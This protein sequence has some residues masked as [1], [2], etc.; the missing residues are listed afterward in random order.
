MPYRSMIPCPSCGKKAAPQPTCPFCH[1]PLD[2]STRK[3]TATPSCTHPYLSSDT[4]ATGS[5]L[6]PRTSCVDKPDADVTKRMLAFLG[7]EIGSAHYHVGEGIPEQKYQNAQKRMKVPEDDRILAILDTT[8]FESGK[9]GVAFGEKHVYTRRFRMSYEELQKSEVLPLRKN[10]IQI[11]SGS[12]KFTIFCPSF[13][14]QAVRFVRILCG[15]SAVY[16]NA[17]TSLFRKP[18]DLRDELVWIARAHTLK[19]DF[20]FVGAAIWKSVAA[21][22]SGRIAKI[23]GGAL[24]GPLG[25]MLAGKDVQVGVLA[26]TDDQLDVVCLGM[27][28]G[29]IA[30]EEHVTLEA[31]ETAEGKHFVRSVSLSGITAETERRQDGKAAQLSIRGQFRAE[32]TFPSSYS[33][34]NVSVAEKMA[35]HINCFQARGN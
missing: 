30:P 12:R 16:C 24:L 19:A 20:A 5:R 26:A 32:C 33:E 7:E 18:R 34:D 10:E 25:I 35:E 29:L 27:M 9:D 2:P 17:D 31:L 6:P 13:A 28:K 22:F 3:T 21:A 15:V 4:T 8:V 11:S 1:G 14:M 23:A